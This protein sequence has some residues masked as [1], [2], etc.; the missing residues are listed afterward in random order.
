MTR[1][2]QLDFMIK[3]LM[4]ESVIS[5]VIE[6]KWKL[7]RSLVNMRQPGPV[8]NTFLRM[9]D[10]YLQSE[11]MAA[12][13][14][15]L[16]DLQLVA[17]KIY[18]WQGDIT[19]LATD[20]IVNAANSG[21]TG[22]YCPCHNCIDNAIH[23][24][25]GVQLRNACASIM[26]QQGYSEPT[27]QAKIT[28]AYNLPSQFIIHT[29]GPIVDG[30][31]NIEHQQQL[32]SC[33][34]K[35]LEMAELYRLESLAFCCISTGEFGFPNMEAASIAYHEILNYHKNGG[36]CRIVFNVFKDKDY[37]LYKRLLIH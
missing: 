14:T 24:Y 15:R 10:D 23:T 21:L 17:D 22:C 12:G 35:C 20:A 16:E 28:K 19:T 25:A 26:A 27:G 8:S 13:I 32:S 2:E 30:Q 1:T 6:E 18:L 36:K 29:V 5:E 11:I 34:R 4:P 33:Y 31:L 3:E 37:Y 9:Q 7:F